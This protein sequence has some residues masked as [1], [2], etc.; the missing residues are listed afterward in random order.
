MLGSA[1]IHLVRWVHYQLERD[2]APSPQPARLTFYR[3][4]SR[5]SSEKSTARPMTASRR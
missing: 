4:Y 5:W 3:T 2:T 1:L